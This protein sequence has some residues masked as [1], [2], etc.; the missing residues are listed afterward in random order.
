LHFHV[1][2]PNESLKNRFFAM[3]ACGASIAAAA[4]VQSSYIH[5]SGAS[6]PAISLG[7]ARSAIALAVRFP[8]HGLCQIRNLLFSC[9]HTLIRWDCGIVSHGNWGI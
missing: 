6:P 1:T 7:C 9:K 3:S 2:S 5:P 4:Q 8:M